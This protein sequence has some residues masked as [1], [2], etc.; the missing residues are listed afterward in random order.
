MNVFWKPVFPVLGWSVNEQ[1][2]GAPLLAGN[3]RFINL[4]GRLLGAHIA[5]AGLI[6]LWAG[7]MTLFECSRFNPDLSMYEQNLILLPH[8]ATLGIGIGEGGQKFVNKQ[9]E[10]LGANVLF[11]FPGK[12]ET[13]QITREAPKTL[14]L[15]DAQAIATQVPTVA[16]VA[17]ELNRRYVVTYRN[18]NT[19]V[20]IIGTTPGFPLVRDFEIAEGRFFNE[21]DIKRS[22]Q[23]V[24]LGADLKEKLFGSANPLG[25]Q[26]RIKNNSFQIIGTLEGKGSGL[27]GANYDEAA[28]IPITTSANRLVGKNSPYG[29]ALDYLVVSARNSKS[30][31]A[32][33]FQIRN[34][35]RLRQF[36]IRVY[37][38]ANRL[39]IVLTLDLM[40]KKN[41]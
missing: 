25:K 7:A 8:L 26:I 33:E 30:V 23:V 29:I 17:P 22:N 28:V 41:C 6:F 39:P 5:H 37:I 21:I 11:G 24:V 1:Q 13:Q 9:L 18:R 20:N 31:D 14:V 4:S 40:F 34:L 38:L 3:A 16:G 19:D 32:A 27:G 35:L 2:T 12:Q 36:S 15:A 10:S